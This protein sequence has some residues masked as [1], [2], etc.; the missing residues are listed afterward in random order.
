MVWITNDKDRSP[1]E[2]LWVP[3]GV[4]GNLAGSLLNLSYGTGRAF[5]VPHEEAGGQWQGA[6]CELPMPA[7]ATGI[8][9]GR[10]AEDGALYTCGMFAWAGNA[11]APG[12]FHR[13]RRGGKPAWVPL[14]IHAAKGALTVTFSD[15]LETASVKPD[16]FAFKIWSLKRTAN[17]GSKHYDEHPLDIQGARLSADGRAV[18]LGIPMLA[19]TQCYELRIKLQ[20]QDGAITERSLHGTIH[21]IVAGK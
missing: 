21:H 15:P 14:G 3:K 1:A 11:T 13:I 12:G 9:R 5:I 6:V 4:W 2:L 17:Y 18:T 16:A 19:P 7:F 10:F 8:M 20:T